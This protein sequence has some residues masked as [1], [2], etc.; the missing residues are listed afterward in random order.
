MF[1]KEREKAEGQP[2][3]F[4]YSSTLVATETRYRGGFF[5]TIQRMMCG[6]NGQVGVYTNMDTNMGYIAFSQQ[7]GT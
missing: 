3:A 2:D 6:E 7:V 4:L 5:A 1:L